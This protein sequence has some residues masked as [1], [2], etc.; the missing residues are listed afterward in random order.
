SVNSARYI[1]ISE[2]AATPDYVVSVYGDT[3]LGKT[4]YSEME[5][6]CGNN[7]DGSEFVGIIIPEQNIAVRLEAIRANWQT[8][9]VVTRS[10][11]PEE[12]WYS[13]WYRGLN[14]GGFESLLFTAG[15][16]YYVFVD[17]H[18]GDQGDFYL[19]ISDTVERT[20]LYDVDIDMNQVIFEPGDEMIIS[21]IIESPYN[22]NVMMQKC[23][24]LG[25]G[26]QYWFFPDFSSEFRT[27]DVT[28][29]FGLTQTLEYQ[30]TLPL[31]ITDNFSMNLY[32][33]L[34]EFDHSSNIVFRS[35]IDH[36]WLSIHSGNW[37]KGD[38]R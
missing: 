38:S 13:D 19:D 12:C 3:R 8:C 25:I 21:T 11:P 22:E 24:L 18:S 14:R 36:A 35:N 2:L 30:L 5:Y 33:A 31:V 34:L 7:L 26:D 17:G 20:E 6:G 9:L 28:F 16:R 27:T 15:Q 37:F 29:G 1:D 10:W 32:F 23:L 4:R